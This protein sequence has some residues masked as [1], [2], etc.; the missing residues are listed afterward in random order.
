[1]E[2]FAILYQRCLYIL[3]LFSETFWLSQACTAAAKRSTCN[4][5]VTKCKH[6]TKPITYL[7]HIFPSRRFEIASHTTNG[8]KNPKDPWNFPKLLFSVIVQRYLRVVPNVWRIACPVF[9]K[10]GGEKHFALNNKERNAMKFPTNVEFSTDIAVHACR[11]EI[12]S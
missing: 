3:P 6:F 8:I 12:N 5:E 2:G 7:G 11:G 4:L 9:N 10:L 1:M